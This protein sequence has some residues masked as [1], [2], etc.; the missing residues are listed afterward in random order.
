MTSAGLVLAAA[1][2]AIWAVDVMANVLNLRRLGR[3]QPDGFRDLYDP[4]E[5]KKMC[6]YNQSQTRL[7]LV[8][9][10]IALV[11]LLGF[12]AL[13]GFGGLAGLVGGV[14]ES[15]ILQGLLFAGA[16]WL[17]GTLMSLPF[18]IYDTFVLEAK[19]G[20]NKTTPATFFGDLVKSTLLMLVLGGALGSM[21]IWLFAAGGTLAW[22]WGAAATAAFMLLMSFLAPQFILPLFNKFEPLGD[23]PLKDAVLDF[24]AKNQFPVGEV[25]VIDGSKRSTKA[26]AFFTGFG[27]TKRIALFDTLINRFNSDEL[28]AVLAH[29]IG[30]FKLRHIVWRIVTMVG[31]VFVYF[32]SA[33][34]AI[35]SGLV[36]RIFGV[37]GASVGIALVLFGIAIK[38]ASWLLGILQSKLSR[39]HEFQAD[40]FA[41]RTTGSGE[42]MISALTKLTKESLGHLDPHPAYIALY[43][44]HPP[45]TQRVGAIRRQDQM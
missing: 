2:L 14:T 36:A 37:E 7:E 16:L 1:L 32:A 22:V 34:L 3:G 40:A 38:P 31:L 41:V 18:S 30:H 27:K 17:A 9:S 33:A 15:V 44:S 4:E 5:Y 23:G 25:S 39:V 8:E 28:V 45:L 29:E 26:N 35:E 24:A 19:Y 12:L 42:P 43:H 20:F 21:V 10:S 13:G 11:V 6:R